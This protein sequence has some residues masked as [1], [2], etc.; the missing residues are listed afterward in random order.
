MNGHRGI[1]KRSVERRSDAVAVGRLDIR[2]G[3]E[4][5]VTLPRRPCPRRPAPRLHLLFQKLPL[6]GVLADQGGG[7]GRE[8]CHDAPANWRVCASI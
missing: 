2:S 4:H 7:L 3:N 6:G 8:P 1:G 5:I